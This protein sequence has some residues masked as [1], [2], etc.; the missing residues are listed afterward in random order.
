MRYD[1][2]DFEAHLPNYHECIIFDAEN[3][4]GLHIARWDP[5]AFNDFGAFVQ[6]TCCVSS[7]LQPFIC[8]PNRTDLA[9]WYCP[10]ETDHQRA[11][12][13]LIVNPTINTEVRQ[14]MARYYPSISVPW[15]TE[16][17]H[18]KIM[19]LVDGDWPE[20]SAYDTHGYYTV[21]IADLT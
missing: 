2:A 1:L 9:E 18:G 13:L 12:K 4:I 16:G 11:R 17:L 10:D 5:V 15:L 3:E 8:N 6:F 19:S 14:W 7:A 20:M 21:F